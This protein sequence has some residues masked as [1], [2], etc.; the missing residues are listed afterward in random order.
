MLPTL[1][2]GVKCGLIGVY[3]EP[4]RHPLPDENWFNKITDFA[5]RWSSHRIKFGGVVGK[6]AYISFAAIVGL[7]G[8]SV[9]AKSVDWLKTVELVLVVGFAAFVVDRILN[10]AS[11]HPEATLEGSEILTWQQQVLG[12]KGLPTPPLEAPSLGGQLASVSQVQKNGSTPEEAR[13]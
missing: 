1:G 10:Y 6:I 12:A 5:A 2:F 3:H 8:I 11:K 7:T 13:E 9:F 4:S